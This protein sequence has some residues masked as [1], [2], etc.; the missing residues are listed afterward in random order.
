MR[1]HRQ[2]EQVVKIDTDAI[3]DY[4]RIIENI[5][6]NVH[7]VF[8]LRISVS[9]RQQIKI[10]LYT[11]FEPTRPLVQEVAE[12]GMACTNF[13]LMCNMTARRF[14][15][16]LVKYFTAYRDPETRKSALELVISSFPEVKRPTEHT[17]HT[18]FALGW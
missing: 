14:Y 7:S 8:V 16:N 1:I 4:L 6:P 17:L 3:E 5:F 15:L 11:E 18:D 10:S 2:M 9:V 12:V 13:E